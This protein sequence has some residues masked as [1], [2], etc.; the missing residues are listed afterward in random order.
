[1]PVYHLPEIKEIL[2]PPKEPI[3]FEIDDFLKNAKNKQ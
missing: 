1:M 3:F 2:Q